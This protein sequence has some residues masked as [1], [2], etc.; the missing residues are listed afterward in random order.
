MTE[1]QSFDSFILKRFDIYNMFHTYYLVI[2]IFQWKKMKD[3][4]SEHYFVRVRSIIDNPMLRII[5]I[6]F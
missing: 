4:G 1:S 5:F 2:M 6:P 3:F